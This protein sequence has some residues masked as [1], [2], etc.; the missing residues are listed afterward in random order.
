MGSSIMLTPPRKP[1]S[2][3]L[4]LTDDKGCPVSVLKANVSGVFGRKTGGCLVVEKKCVVEA[5]DSY[6]AVVSRLRESVI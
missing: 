4:E 2:K 1:P 6:E 5:S 3:W